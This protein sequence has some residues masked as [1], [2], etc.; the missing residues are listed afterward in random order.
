MTMA[1]WLRYPKSSAGSRFHA[2]LENAREKRRGPDVCSEAAPG[3]I[4][5]W[6]CYIMRSGYMRLAISAIVAMA[7]TAGQLVMPESLI[8]DYAGYV[9]MTLA[10]LG[11]YMVVE[12][13][14]ILR[15][16]A[17]QRPGESKG[18]AIR[19]L[20]GGFLILLIAVADVLPLPPEIGSA[21]ES[22]RWIA[23]A[24]LSVY[25]FCEALMARRRFA[26]TLGA[27]TNQSARHAPRAAASETGK[28][29]KR[30]LV[31][32]VLML[33]LIVSYSK[34]M[35][36]DFLPAG[37]AAYRDVVL[38]AVAL[39]ILIDALVA[40]RKQRGENVTN[41]DTT[42]PIKVPRPPKHPG[43]RGLRR[44][45]GFPLAVTG[46]R[47]LYRLRDGR[48]HALQRHAGRGRLPCRAPGL[49]GGHPRVF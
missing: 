36:A 17:A 26:E 29:I 37:L 38:A 45:V 7:L 21:A 25:V 9:A 4:N 42:Q 47:A 31:L 33:F 10:G 49:R 46:K 15:R 34:A 6:G 14:L 5:N 22:Y 41:P 2:R 32:S 35:T 24:A 40:V 8:V 20:M 11:A 44:G 16:T 13:V 48:R 23:L 43:G 12:G 30:I 28:P 39:L 3:F 19:I 18:S 27:D 1:E